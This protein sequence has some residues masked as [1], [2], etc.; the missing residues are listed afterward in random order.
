[1]EQWNG[2][3]ME[4]W[5]S[6]GCLTILI[7]SSIPLVEGPL[8]QHCIIPEPIIPLFQHSNIPIG[9]KP[10]SSYSPTAWRDEF[11]SNLTNANFAPILALKRVAKKV[12][13]S[14]IIEE[15]RFC[16]PVKRDRKNAFPVNSSTYIT[17]ILSI[18]LD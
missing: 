2:G 8:I 13:R 11:K 7:L 15:M 14:S 5:F 10:L 18:K 9:A 4:Y 6:K 1:M 16:V 17:S 12:L 3:T